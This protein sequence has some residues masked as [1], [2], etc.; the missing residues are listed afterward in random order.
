MYKLIIIIITFL[1]PSGYNILQDNVLL[2]LL[3]SWSLTASKLKW[4]DPDT[5][6]HFCTCT[7]TFQHHSQNLT[8]S[9]SSKLQPRPNCVP[10]GLKLSFSQFL[11]ILTFLWYMISSYRY[12]LS[13]FC[14]GSIFLNP[15]SFTFVLTL[16]NVWLNA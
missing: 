5:N 10:A 11:I 8:F 2:H 6:V 16:E 9:T 3:A 1:G 4:L 7:N 13:R 12:F 15:E 14:L